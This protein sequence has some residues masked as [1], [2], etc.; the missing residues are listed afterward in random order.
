MFMAVDEH[1]GGQ[2][3]TLQWCVEMKAKLS[4]TLFQDLGFHLAVGNVLSFLPQ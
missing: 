2:L 3:P 1:C 4:F